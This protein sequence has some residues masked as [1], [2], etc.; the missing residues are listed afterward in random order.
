MEE[1]SSLMLC[2]V[3]VIHRL[4]HF[5]FIN[6]T[7]CANTPPH[8]G[9]VEWKNRHLLEIARGLILGYTYVDP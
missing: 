9:V 7:S 8:Y 2:F 6:Q 5:L 1:S 3:E 4:W